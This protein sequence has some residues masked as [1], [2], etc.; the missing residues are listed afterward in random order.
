MYKIMLVS[1][2]PNHP[3]G[4]I[5]NETNWMKKRYKTYESALQAYWQVKENMK[6]VLNKDLGG[7]YWKMEIQHCY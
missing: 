4:Y 6:D 3:A 2:H 5:R 7:Y 1:I